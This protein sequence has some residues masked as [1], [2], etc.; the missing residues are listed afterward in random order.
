MP[1][2]PGLEWNREVRAT[3]DGTFAGSLSQAHEGT[4]LPSLSDAGARRTAGDKSSV[5]R[6]D[7]ERA[8]LDL[9]KPR[10]DP[11]VR[12][13]R[14][15]PSRRARQALLTVRCGLQASSSRGPFLQER[16][17]TRI[18]HWAK[19]A[20]YCRSSA[21]WGAESRMPA[22]QANGDVSVGNL[23]QIRPGKPPIQKARIGLEKTVNLHRF[24]QRV[25]DTLIPGKEPGPC[26]HARQFQQVPGRTEEHRAV[27]RDEIEIL[28]GESAEGC[29][30]PKMFHHRLPGETR[31]SIALGPM[32][33]HREGRSPWRERPSDR[34]RLRPRDRAA[35]RSRRVGPRPD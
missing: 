1:A 6:P 29:L 22:I 34:S 3:R 7:H 12:V 27:L 28:A 9:G 24:R 16:R 17:A 35:T 4:R 26:N 13:H 2:S 32:N 33:H 5:F 21:G 11:S 30:C 14:L 20:R 25:T 8:R 15:T 23:P 10:S 18:F 31:I 19:H